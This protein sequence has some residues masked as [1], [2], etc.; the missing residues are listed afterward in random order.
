ML[1]Y[2]LLSGLVLLIIEYNYKILNNFLSIDCISIYL[3]LSFLL[4]SLNSKHL[5][6]TS[7]RKNKDLM[8]NYYIL[9]ICKLNFIMLLYSFIV[10]SK[11][12]NL[13][14]LYLPSYLEF[15]EFKG[16]RKLCLKNI[17]F[18][19]FCYFFKLIGN[20]EIMN[21]Y[22][23]ITNDKQYLIGF[24]PHGLFPFGTVGSLGLP[25]CN[26]LVELF[27][28]RYTNKLYIGIASFCFY[29]P[30]LRDFFLSLGAID[31]SKPIIEKFIKNGNSIGL[32]IGGAE[33]A[34]FS[35]YG[36]TN[37]IINKRNGFFKLALENNLTI[38]PI[39]TFGNNNIYNSYDKDFFHIF[40][41]FKRITGI[42]FPR[43]QII[44]N[45]INFYSVSGYHI[46]INKKNNIQNNDI[47]ELKL[48]YIEKLKEVF[49]KY[50][51]IDY[52]VKNKNL[53]I[54]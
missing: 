37:L 19:P 3:L 45:K 1:Y 11:F 13:F 26:N 10:N 46:D 50:K 36:N 53:I 42:W 15:S 25:I 43:G 38:V 30:I 27:P 39:Y 9:F 41:Y 7:Y 18:K 48:L 40:Y 54:N 4:T 31:C 8:P 2:N 28:V 21:D 29:I 24:H 16:N 47:E 49:D 12:N 22:K 32:F 52:S 14:L 23:I 44:F 35:D 6:G 51:F 5:Q 20:Y 33:E 17:L 34:K